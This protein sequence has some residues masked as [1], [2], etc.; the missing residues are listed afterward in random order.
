[1]MNY[2]SDDLPDD[3]PDEAQRGPCEECGGDG[4]ERMFGRRR[5]LCDECCEALATE[6]E[7]SVVVLEW[8]DTDG[9]THII[10]VAA[11]AA[12]ESVGTRGLCAFGY[13]D[14]AT[15]E[16]DPFGEF[17]DAVDRGVVC[18][19]GLGFPTN[20]PGALFKTVWNMLFAVSGG[21]TVSGERTE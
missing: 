2:F 19:I 17:W 4:V 18:T 10:R 11:D 15:M 21:M 6:G 20:G 16:N 8:T 14:D 7:R 12:L 9:E 5:F 13:D 3:M 1:M